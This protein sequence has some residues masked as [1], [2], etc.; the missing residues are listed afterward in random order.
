[1]R[2]RTSSTRPAATIDSTRASIRWC[3]SSRRRRNTKTRHSSAGRPSSNCNCWWLIGSPVARYT[4]KR[5]DQPPRIVRVDMRGGHR[6]DLRKAIIQCLFADVLKLLFNFMPQRPIGG[7][8]IEQTTQ[9]AFQ[10]QR[11]ATDEQR[12]AAASADFAHHRCGG[13]HV[14]SHA[15]LVGRIDDVDEVVRHKIAERARRLGGADIHAAING[16]RIERDDLGAEPLGQRDADAR[17][18]DGRRPGKKP[19]V[20]KGIGHRLRLSGGRPKLGPRL[21]L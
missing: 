16:H 4:S 5:P 21:L 19:A 11:R 12:F 8:A 2:P 15:E 17:F 10:V 18:A 13:I 7:R 14:L 6:I 3:N 1:M 20:V 9:Q